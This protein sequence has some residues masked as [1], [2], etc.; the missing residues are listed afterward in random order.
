M[1]LAERIKEAIG[2]R[3]PADIARATKKTRGAVSQ[4]MA[5]KILS[6]KADTAMRLQ[7]VTGYNAVWI[8]TGKGPKKTTDSNVIFLPVRRKVPLLSWEQA[9]RITELSS[10]MLQ[11]ISDVGGVDIDFDGAS[12]RTFA[13]RVAGDSMV[14]PHPVE[15]SFT[16]GTVI[17]V[18][19]DRPAEA[20][21]YVLAR[22]ASS[23]EATF[24]RLVR[25]GGR[26]FLKPSNPAYPT[27][28]V[29]DVH[30]SI[31]GRVIEAQSRRTL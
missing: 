9:A 30:Q 10:D 4:W 3:S 28:E 1:T 12:P 16:D 13:L 15:L 6:L 29:F 17:V 5:G 23:G 20:G 14:S 22:D 26:W 25:D 7:E 11:E 31:I 27:Q 18:D 8:A 2:D 24:K 21:D 19:P